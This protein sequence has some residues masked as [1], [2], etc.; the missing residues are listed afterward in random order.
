MVQYWGFSYGTILGA[1]L[2]AMYPDRIQRAILDGVADSH[3]YMAGSWT[4]NLA[5]TDLEFIKLAEYCWLA[6]PSK[7]LIYDEDGPAVII[8]TLAAILAN[9]TTNPI[10]VPGTSTSGPDVVTYDDL[11]RVFRTIVYNPLGDFTRTVRILAGIRDRN[12]TALAAY[13]RASLPDL[14]RP[15]SEACLKAGPYSAE[16][17]IDTHGGEST[18]GIACSDALP[19]L[20][21]TKDSYREY[22]SKIQ[23]QSR[24]LGEDWATIQLPCTAWHARPEWRYE[25]NFTAKTAHPILF[26]GNTIDPVTPLRNAFLMSAGFEGSGV[27][28]QDGEGHCTWSGVSLCSGR[29]VRQYFQSGELPKPKKGDKVEVCKVDRLPLDGYSDLEAH[30]VEVPEGEEDVE[31][32]RALVGFNK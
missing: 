26:V 16:C 5:D 1:T 15:L 19:R 29:A 2:S 28:Q 32:W 21:Q 11:K 22:A 10:G 31:L 17:N 18:Y 14:K 3:D 6:G 7:C 24:L 23:A 12:G 20:N 27:L 8:D 4:T 13:K 30:E 25:G 9:F